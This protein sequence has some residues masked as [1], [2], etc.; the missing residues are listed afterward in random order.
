MKILPFVYR[1]AFFF[2]YLFTLTHALSTNLFLRETSVEASVLGMCIFERCKIDI[3][4]P[5]SRLVA[6]AFL[7]RRFESIYWKS[8]FRVCIVEK[9]FVK[10]Y[11]EHSFD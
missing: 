10:Y 9:N 6:G 8:V 1:R 3:R 5:E 2:L 11:K 4:C 7:V